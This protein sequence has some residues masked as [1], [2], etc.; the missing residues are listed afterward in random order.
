MQKRLNIFVAMPFG[1]KFDLIYRY[2]IKPPL[3]T[4]GHKVRRAD[5]DPENQNINKEIFQGIWQADLVIADLTGQNVNV[6][7]ELGIAHSLKKPTIQIAQSLDDILF[8]LRS[9]EAKI[10]SIK[11]DGSSDLADL[12][13][14]IIERDNYNFS[15]PFDDFINAGP[16]KRITLPRSSGI[17][18]D[19]DDNEEA[20]SD[21]SD[22]GLLD[23]GADV[24]DAMNEIASITEKIG[25]D[26][27]TIGERMQAHTE[28][29]NKL[30]SNPNQQRIQN[31]KLLIIRK[32]A[33]DLNEFSDNVNQKIPD[34][35]EAWIKLDQGL[36]HVLLISNIENQSDL[37][38]VL[39]LLEIMYDLRDKESTAI[40]STESFRDSYKNF[41]GL[42]RVSN[43]AVRNSVKTTDK[44]LDE[45]KL[46]DSVLTRL[47]DLA[48]DL[49][50]RYNANMPDNGDDDST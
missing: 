32:F 6:C 28:E 46:G 20:A 22:Y 45:F 50:D 40:K 30:A 47:I 24:E 25:L 11:S 41:I 31:K 9:Y 1:G 19:V 10:Y 7:Y 29:A 15:N 26:I 16:K 13:C 3:G 8:N 48:T 34:L 18:D 14:A 43:R 39:S 42:S 44:L 17:D 35:K 12:I 36:G 21:D 2:L 5:D 49:I 33:S 27:S 37:E 38:A 4:E 23:A